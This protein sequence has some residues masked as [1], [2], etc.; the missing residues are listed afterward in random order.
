MTPFAKREQDIILSDLLLAQKLEAIVRNIADEIKAHPYKDV[1][2]LTQA[3]ILL[4]F[5]FDLMMLYGIII[6]KS[7]RDELQA[8]CLKYLPDYL[9]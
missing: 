7:V 4:G 1:T 5:A 8:A 6:D 9:S 2:P 3:T